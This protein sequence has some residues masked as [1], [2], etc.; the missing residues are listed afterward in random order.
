M[1]NYYTNFSLVLP[2]NQE[3]QEYA[4]NLVKQVQAY[5]DDQPLPTDFPEHLRETVEDWSFEVQAVKDGLWINSQEGGQ[6]TACLF[7]Q[8][9]LQRYQFA[10]YV[11]FQWSHDCD[12]PRLDG[13]GGGAAFITSTQ[14]ET[15]CTSE[16]LRTKIP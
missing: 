16:W 7:I 3:Q 12:K 8:Q 5:R 13:F 2:L 14:I 10:P 1:A 4:L 11:A 15:F 9:L 6:D